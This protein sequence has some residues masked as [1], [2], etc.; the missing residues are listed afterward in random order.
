MRYWKRKWCNFHLYW[1][2]IFFRKPIKK[3]WN[4][5][6]SF[7]TVKNAICFRH[8]KSRSWFSNR[9]SFWDFWLGHELQYKIQIKIEFVGDLFVDFW[10]SLLEKS[11]EVINGFLV[12]SLLSKKLKSLK[13]DDLLNVFNAN[14]LYPI[15]LSDTDSHNPKLGN[16]FL[17]TKGM[18][19]D[20]IF[21]INYETFREVVSFFHGKSLVGKCNCGNCSYKRVNIA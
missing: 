4:F 19:G 8:C 14:G 16:G 1:P 3:I 5:W 9:W 12:S 7:R 21:S 20:A 15:V 18:N 6:T 13:K 17:F 10:Q 11:N 2:A